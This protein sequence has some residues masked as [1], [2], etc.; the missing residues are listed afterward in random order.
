MEGSV[1]VLRAGWLPTRQANGIQTVRMCEAFAALGLRVSL[2]HISHPV[3]HEDIIKYYNIKMPINLKRLP[4]AVLPWRKHFKLNERWSAIP[5]FVHAFL[6]CGFVVQ[7]ARRENALFYFVREPMLAWWL[8]FHNLPTVFEI[9]HDYTL[10]GID[11]PFTRLAC[12]RHSI[13]SVVAVT[14]HMQNDLIRLFGVPA[15]KTLALP[16]GVDLQRFSNVC[17]GDVARQ[18]LGLAPEAQVVV[19]TGQL[20]I[21]KGVDVLVRAA[22]LLKNVTVVLVGGEAADQNRLRQLIQD[23]GAHNIILL[24]YVPPTEVASYLKAAN[25]LVMPHSAKVTESAKYTCPLK[26]FEY[27]AAGVPIVASELP[28]ITDVIRH[29]ENGWLVEPDSPSALA[30]GIRHLLENKSLASAMARKAK[31]D[32]ESYTWE[33]RAARIIESLRDKGDSILTEVIA[34]PPNMAESDVLRSTERYSGTAT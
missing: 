11:N 28:A 20:H 31:Q 26:L 27:M 12:Q 33:H 10:G 22:A 34:R 19:Y 17:T 5:S 23:I 24:D 4:R 2:Y 21:E 3:I 18:Q 13:K 32:S 7:L 16:N 30:E 6:W 29:G 25:V 1:V 14:K 8:G 15:E 9:H